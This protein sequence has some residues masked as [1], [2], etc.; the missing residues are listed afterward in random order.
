MNLFLLKQYGHVDEPSCTEF[1]LTS[2]STE[3]E[4]IMV[5]SRWNKESMNFSDY[6]LSLGKLVQTPVLRKILF[7][8]VF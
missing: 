3:M 4:S 8:N 1:W 6:G 5:S 7:P 2:W